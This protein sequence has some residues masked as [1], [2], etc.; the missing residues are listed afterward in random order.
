MV[1]GILSPENFGPRKIVFGRT[2]SRWNYVLT[3]RDDEGKLLGNVLLKN[4]RIS[5]IK[6][7]L[8]TISDAVVE[9]KSPR[10]ISLL[11]TAMGAYT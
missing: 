2:S 7:T 5:F 8:A 10:Q 11:V 1:Q 4:P 3:V 9:G 6:A